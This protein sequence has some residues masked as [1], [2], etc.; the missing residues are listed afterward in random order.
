M[1]PGRDS[2]GRPLELGGPQD[3]DSLPPFMPASQ[4]PTGCQ[5]GVLK[6]GLQTSLSPGTGFDHSRSTVSV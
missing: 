5:L 3:S 2:D 6:E 4:P 1:S